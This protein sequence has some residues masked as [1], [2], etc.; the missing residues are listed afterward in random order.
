M[1]THI[2]FCTG[3]N[4]TGKTV[5]LQA[6]MQ[7]DDPLVQHMV[8]HSSIIR[9]FSKSK[10]LDTEADV[11]ALPPDRALQ[12]QLDLYRYYWTQVHSRVVP[13]KIN[14]FDRSPLCHLAHVLMYASRVPTSKQDV[15]TW[16]GEGI[17]G[18]EELGRRWVTSRVGTTPSKLVVF[19]F[20]T[21]WYTVDHA[22]DEYRAVGYAKNLVLDAL[23]QRLK[24][25]LFSTP[26]DIKTLV[27]EFAPHIR[28]EVLLA[29]LKDWV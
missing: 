1:D 12:Y 15:T 29:H 3:A 9:G 8:M 4:G 18:I 26:T 13:G 24:P 6:L 2:V 11:V 23:I 14:V 16:I 22:V 20:P 25:T 27:G 21:S 10:G 28:A 5:T 17:T 19:P 7:I